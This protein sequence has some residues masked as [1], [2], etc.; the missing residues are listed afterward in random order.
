MIRSATRGL[1][2]CALLGGVALVWLVPTGAGAQTTSPNYPVTTTATTSPCTST[3]GSVCG[4]AP[5]QVA[6]A[7]TSLPFTGGNVALVTI[8]GLVIVAAGVVL[9]RLGRR[10]SGL[11]S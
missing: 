4:T 11:P 9:V 10:R 2:L 8:L 6:A 5:P 1:V 3:T 7:G